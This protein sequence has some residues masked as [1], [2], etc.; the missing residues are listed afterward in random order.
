MEHW[1]FYSPINFATENWDCLNHWDELS[2][3]PD[4]VP[5]SPVSEYDPNLVC[6]LP[7]SKKYDP[8]EGSVYMAHGGKTDW[9]GGHVDRRTK[10]YHFHSREL[11]GTRWD[12]KEDAYSAYC[13]FKDKEVVSNVQE[14]PVISSK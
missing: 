9:M 10:Q 12:N 1:K 13:S 11:K 5:F 7:S 6:V 14:V 3:F 8:V 4:P 2:R